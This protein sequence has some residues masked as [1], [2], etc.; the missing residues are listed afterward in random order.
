MSSRS[1]KGLRSR[2]KKGGCLKPG[3][4]GHPGGK[5]G[6]LQARAGMEAR[7]PGAQVGQRWEGP[8][9][10]TSGRGSLW[11]LWLSQPVSSLGCPE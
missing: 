3:E 9:M 8:P 7:T 11:F 1:Q 4:K 6:Y 2:L 10:S 5:C